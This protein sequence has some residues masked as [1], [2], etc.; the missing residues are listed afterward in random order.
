MSDYSVKL[1]KLTKKFGRRLVFRDVNYNFFA[2]NIYG[3]AGSNGSGKS[4]LSKIIAGVIS[5]TK[6]EITHKMNG[7]KILPEKLHEFIGFVSPYLVLYGEFTAEENLRHIARIRGIS[8][9]FEYVRSLFD[10]FELYERRKDLLKGYSSGM[11]QRMKFIF[12]LQHRPALLLLD[13]PTSNLDN[14]GKDTVYEVIENYGKE[15]LVIIASNE[16]NDLSL[17]KELLH[18]EDFKNNAGKG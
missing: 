7:K 14:K 18:I 6:G 10:K 15:N 17:C 4:T 11:L 16:D 9:D 8:Y 3:L 12:A 2:G 13:E 5:P 1:K